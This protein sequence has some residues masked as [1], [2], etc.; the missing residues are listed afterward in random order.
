MDEWIVPLTYELDPSMPEMDRWAD[1]LG[2]YDG[3]ASRPRPGAVDATVHAPMSM[4]VWDTGRKLADAV[5]HVVGARPTGVEVIT[6]AELFR[7]AGEPTMPELMS[8]AEIGQELGVSRQRVHKL[9]SM[10]EF[11]APLAELRGGA[12]WD[13]AAV[14]KFA[15][16][17]ERKPGR[18]RVLR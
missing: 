9:R 4:D 7:R 10:P 14:R 11:P 8:A 15:V 13:A 16:R 2:E 6:E 1:Q 17:W 18:P 3:H 12:V 5:E